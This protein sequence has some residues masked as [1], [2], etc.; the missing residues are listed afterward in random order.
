MFQADS[1][2]KVYL[3]EKPKKKR[4]S[5]EP[6]TT[7]PVEVEEQT[8]PCE[9]VKDMKLTDEQLPDL[10]DNLTLGDHK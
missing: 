3:R 7:K 10:L 9:L 5:K 2:S 4:H 8:A 6:P 1:N